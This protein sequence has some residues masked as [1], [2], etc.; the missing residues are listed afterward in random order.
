[1]ARGNATDQALGR[2]SGKV[3]ARAKYV[4]R[5][6]KDEADAWRAALIGM[7]SENDAVACE[8][9]RYDAIADLCMSAFMVLQRGRK[10]S[11]YGAPSPLSAIDIHAYHKSLSIPIG[12]E[13]FTTG[14]IAADNVWL[15]KQFKRIEQERKKDGGNSNG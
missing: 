11:E 6:E 12:I 5:D 8:E 3:E 7:S 13:E 2:N 9:P 15:D 1:M 10:Y 4:F 14:V